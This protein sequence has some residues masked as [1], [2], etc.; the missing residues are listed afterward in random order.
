MLVEDSRLKQ[1]KRPIDFA[2]SKLKANFCA[3][4]VSKAS[5]LLNGRVN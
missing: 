1:N 3:T 5:I 4:P 2:Q